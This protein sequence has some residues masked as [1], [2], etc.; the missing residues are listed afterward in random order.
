MPSGNSLILDPDQTLR[1]GKTT[2]GTTTIAEGCAALESPIEEIVENG[3]DWSE[4]E[5]GFQIIDR[6]IVDCLGWPRSTVRP[7]QSD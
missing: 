2:R 6:I 7:E 1:I 3:L 4:A 5:T